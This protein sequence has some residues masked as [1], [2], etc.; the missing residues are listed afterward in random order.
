MAVAKLKVKEPRLMTFAAYLE[1][2][3]AAFNRNEIFT[4]FRMFND[5]LSDYIL[6]SQD[7]QFIDRFVRQDDDTWNLHAYIR[8]DAVCEI[9]AIDCKLSLS[10]VYQ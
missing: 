3:R 7:N 4:R 2:E 10:E 5:T 1:R 8:L 6:V 9:D